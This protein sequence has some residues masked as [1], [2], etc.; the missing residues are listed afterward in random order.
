M[1]PRA[2]VNRT[3]RVKQRMQNPT[4]EELAQRE[5][6]ERAWRAT[7][8]FNKLIPQ[9][10]SYV[11]AVARDSSLRVQATA[12]VTCTDGRTVYIRPPLSLGDD[13]KHVKSDCNERDKVTRRQLCPA[14][15]SREMVMA[16]VY[17]EVAHIIFGTMVEPT[18]EGLAPIF[19]LINEWHPSSVCDHAEK[20]TKQIEQWK[21]QGDNTYLAY[22]A[23][24]TESL[25][26]LV[27][28]LE[29]AR[30]NSGMFNARPGTRAMMDANIAEVFELGVEVSTDEEFIRWQDRTLDEQIFIGSFLAASDYHNH[31]DTLSED[32]R[33][34]LYSAAIEAYISDVGRCQDIHDIVR[35]TVDAWRKFQ[36]LGHF[37]LPKCVKQE[38]MPS[39]SDC[40]S[41]DGPSG[42]I[43]DSESGQ[44][45]EDSGGGGSES[46]DSSEG[47]SGGSEHS[48]SPDG[49][50]STTGESGSGVEPELP[51]EFESESGDS[52]NEAGSAE[53]DERTSP[54]ASGDLDEGESAESSGSGERAT[55]RVDRPSDS[56]PED[57]RT[58][59]QGSSQSDPTAGG[60]KETGEPS[61]NSSR[62]DQHHDGIGSEDSNE[63]N[64]DSDG[65]EESDV[66]TDDEDPGTHVDESDRLAEI[67]K[68]IS[69]HGLI[70]KIDPTSNTKEFACGH[71]ER[72]RVPV[73]LNE[74]QHE[75]ES[76]HEDEEDDEYYE[77]EMLI[78][79]GGVG[80]QDRE[81]L[82]AIAQA[83]RF[84]SPSVELSGI[85][86]VEFPH[87]RTG[88]VQNY[89]YPEK[90]DPKTFMP[91][92]A[93][94]GQLTMAAKLAFEENRRAKYQSNLKSGRVRG[95]SLAKRVPDND[96]RMFQ[97][98]KVPGKRSHHVVIGIDCSG[99][100]NM[101]TDDQQDRIISR[102]KRAAF[103]EAEMLSR[104]GISFEVWGHS[105]GE[106]L[107]NIADD[108]TQGWL[109]A[110]K[111]AN[112]AWDSKSKMRLASIGPVSGNVDGHTLEFY[113]KQAEQSASLQKHIRY[114][115]DGEMPA[116]NY[117][118][119]LSVLIREIDYCKK[120]G[121]NLL[122]VGIE[123]DSPA[124]HG[125]NNVRVDSD[126][127]LIKVVQQLQRAVIQ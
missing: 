110:I 53:S 14:C 83:M 8:A 28:A 91:N 26:L 103:G 109:F 101:F 73:P 35:V 127:D 16:C 115:T 31:L 124:E 84:D 121:I 11:R 3:Q 50:G 112:Q 51:S 9:L 41:D 36:E 29:D 107:N 111:R 120:N 96:P 67:A 80:G 49:G 97:K 76:V 72:K 66:E 12:G 44:T 39:I 105:A 100:T 62:L 116:M 57:K 75:E 102:I 37:V 108:D 70:K 74:D 5:R 13:I 114:Y 45:S 81:L 61:G 30:V 82:I 32:A 38:E 95:R 78:L 58:A 60:D 25:K 65:N 21:A 18:P 59:E 98:K 117:E 92:E 48:A 118:D 64:V 1:P 17:H 2:K 23:G 47:S 10:T 42:E 63:S 86:E 106:G 55:S 6:Y 7:R 77:E 4:A 90:S 71:T 15:D 99:S 20:I 46:G 85:T 24:F 79:V 104:L 33:E 27:N 119:E 19:D 54:E 40:E 94:L 56:Q 122:S 87:T 125:F 93:V 89:Q 69:L 34:V 43:D 113:R 88:W 123:T 68:R 52:E 22:A 126:A